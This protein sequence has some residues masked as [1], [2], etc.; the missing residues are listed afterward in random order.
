MDTTVKSNTSVSICTE[1]T[2]VVVG[3]QEL[4]PKNNNKVLLQVKNKTKLDNQLSQ[5]WKDMN[6][7]NKG[8]Y[9]LQVQQEE[10]WC[11]NNSG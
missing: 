1:D 3:T 6:E 2:L 7:V 8:Q 9:G 10:S 11:Y 4:Q 5:E